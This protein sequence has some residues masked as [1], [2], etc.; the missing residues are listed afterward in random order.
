MNGTRRL[1]IKAAPTHAALTTKAAATHDAESA[2]GA[3]EVGSIRAVAAPLQT[4]AM[5]KPSRIRGGIAVK[6][7][8]RSSGRV[9]RP[10]ASGRFAPLARV[11]ACFTEAAPFQHGIVASAA[12]GME[13]VTTQE[14]VSGSSTRAAHANRPI[15]YDAPAQARA[16]KGASLT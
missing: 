12:K 4:C 16:W 10:S 8:R 9:L 13:D 5:A 14:A 3:F 1:K 15:A 2:P 7:S 6:R 11:V